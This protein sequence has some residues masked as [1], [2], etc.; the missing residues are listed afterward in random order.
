MTGGTYWDTGVAGLTLGFAFLPTLCS[1]VSYTSILISR[2]GFGYLSPIYGLAVDHLISVDLVMADG[3]LHTVS[4]D[5]DPELFWA[6]RGFYYYL[7]KM[8]KQSNLFP[9]SSNH[10]TY[11]SLFLSFFASRRCWS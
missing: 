2:G 5:S 9:I 8:T 6:L 4:K 1:L 10:N 3:K 11:F 7:K